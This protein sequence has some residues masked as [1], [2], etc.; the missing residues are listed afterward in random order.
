VLRLKVG[1]LVNGNKKQDVYVLGTNNAV[2]RRIETGLVGIEYVEINTG[3]K[4]GEKVLI[5]SSNSFR[6]SEEIHIK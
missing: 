5:S 1:E 6:H 4:E 2:R 3:L